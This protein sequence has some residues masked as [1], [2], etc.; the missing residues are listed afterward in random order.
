MGSKYK[1]AIGI[2]KHTIGN[3]THELT[4]E[5]DDNYNFLRAKDEAQKKNDGALLHKRVGELYFNMVS[6][7]YPSLSEEDHKELKN[8]I[9]VNIS[10]ILEDFLIAFRWTTVEDLK[11]IKKKLENQDETSKEKN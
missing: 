2:W 1:E 7:A 11:N 9:G 10:K 4:P 8:W 6:R 5:E 3:I